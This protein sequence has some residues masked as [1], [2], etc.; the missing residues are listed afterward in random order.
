MHEDKTIIS[1]NGG[2][3]GNAHSEYLSAL[4]E[5]GFIGFLLLIFMII[6]IFYKSILLYYHES[7]E[8]KKIY[9]LGSIIGLLTYFIHGLFN[10]FLDLDKA[11][12]PIWFFVAIIVYLDIKIVK[13]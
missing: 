8:M 12:F 10:N 11:A 6:S 2:D 3:M 7:D 1:T 4:S 9:L 5:T 13:T